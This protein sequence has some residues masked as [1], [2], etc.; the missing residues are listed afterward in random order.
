MKLPIASAAATA[1]LLLSPGLASAAG[2]FTVF[3]DIP[4][5]GIYVSTPPNYTPPPGVVMLK[6]GTR[7][8]SKLTKAQ[9]QTLGTD[10]KAR[11]TY[12]AQCDNYDRLG[13]LFLMIKPK[14]VAPVDGDPIIEIARWITP[15]SNYWNGDKAT[16][17]FADADLSAFAGLMGNRTVDVWLGLDGGSNP[18]SG[19]PCTNRDVTPDFRA[20]GFRYSVDLL[21]TTARVPTKGMPSLPVPYGDYTAVPVAGSAPSNRTGTGRAVVIVSGHGAASGGNEYKNTTDTLTVNGTVVGSF[22]T[23]VNCASY[24][25]YSP[26]GNPFLFM[27]N[28]TYNPRNWCPGALVAAQTFPVTLQSTNAVSLDMSDASVPEGSYYRTSITL[29]PN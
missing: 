11:V 21:S 15:F 1:C 7:Y 5:F 14:G 18:Y 17:V 28:L 4:Q 13:G 24:R 3:D 6:N 9:K 22:S 20:V 25:K 10:L 23:Q 26:D 27:G 16:Y 2:Q 29:L 19:D 8:I 12:H